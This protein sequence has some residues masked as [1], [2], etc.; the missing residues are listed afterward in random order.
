MRPAISGVEPI[1]L[2]ALREWPPLHVEEFAEGD[3]RDAKRLGAP[4]KP[5]SEG[6]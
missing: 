5:L 3:R 2:P 6:G 1:F 4:V